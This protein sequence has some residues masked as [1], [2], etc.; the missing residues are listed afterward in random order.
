MLREDAGHSMADSPKPTIYRYNWQGTAIFY[1]V[2]GPVLAMIF[3]RSLVQSLSVLLLVW[4][5][6]IAA[7]WADRRRRIEIA[8]DQVLYQPGIGSLEITKFSGVTSISYG[9][10]ITTLFLSRAFV[11]GAKLVRASDGMTSAIPLDLSRRREIFEQI[12]R[13]WKLYRELHGE[14]SKSSQSEPRN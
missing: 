4:L 7:T 11:D 10:V 14:D 8:D 6:G 9:L 2:L 12:T 1:F 5:S 3:R 13:A